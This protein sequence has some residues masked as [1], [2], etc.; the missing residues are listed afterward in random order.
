MLLQQLFNDAI[1]SYRYCERYVHLTSYPLVSVVSE[2]NPAYTSYAGKK[3][4]DLPI[5][6]V[7]S[8]IL[9]TNVGTRRVPNITDQFQRDGLLGFPVHPQVLRDDMCPAVE[10][11]SKNATKTETIPVIPTASWRTFL[12]QNDNLFFI[13]THFPGR[14]GMLLRALSRKKVNRSHW[15]PDQLLR[16]V[17][18]PMFSHLALFSD[19]MSLSSDYASGCAATIREFHPYP[20]VQG[21]YA[22][23]PMFSLCSQDLNA[24]NDPPLLIQLANHQGIPADDYLVEVIIK[25]H[26][27]LWGQV[28]FHAGLLPEMHGQNTVLLLDPQGNVIRFCVRDF[29]NVVIW[30]E[31]RE[32]LGLPLPD[33]FFP[34]ERPESLG[35]EL[36][37]TYDH[38][39]AR[40]IFDPLVYIVSRHGFSPKK[41]Q[42]RIAEAFDEFNP[43][44]R[45]HFA[46]TE[47]NFRGSLDAVRKVDTQMKPRFR[48]A[49]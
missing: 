6:W 23:L 18:Q 24:P 32:Q 37:I 38:L 10:F 34:H 11:L 12:T 14:I 22:L 25:P 19:L 33:E 15:I 3:V 46:P 48:R 16:L 26:I 27:R 47:I 2:M 9:I 20:H 28:V 30:R 5:L 17:D 35:D 45:D 7:P 31:R 13:K 40:N 8:E 43:W 49:H 1:N 29:G 39:I 36:S 44:A 41:L 42:H 21:P 4:V